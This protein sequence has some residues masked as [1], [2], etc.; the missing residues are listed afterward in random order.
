MHR[1]IC[2]SLCTSFPGSAVKVLIFHYL[3]LHESQLIPFCNVN[4]ECTSIIF[5]TFRYLLFCHEYNRFTRL[6]IYVESCIPKYSFHKLLICLLKRKF[7]QICL[8][9]RRRSL[10]DFAGIIKYSWTSLEGSNFG[11]SGQRQGHCTQQH[12]AFNF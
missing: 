8:C 7:T 9:I 10:G 3:S 11:F 5:A 4:R 6:I 1:S 12:I 2:N